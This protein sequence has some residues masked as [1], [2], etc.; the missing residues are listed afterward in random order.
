MNT[1]T[2]N[3]FSQHSDAYAQAR[4]RYPRELYDWLIAQ[5]A[6]QDAAWDCATGNG[7][8]AVDLSPYFAVV[9]ATDIS[10]EQVGEGFTQ[11]NIHYSVHPAEQTGF[12][13]NTFDL[14][15]VAQALHW[16]DFPKFW[17]E[18]RRVA[19]P[20]ALFCAWG[21]AWFDCDQELDNEFVQPFRALI[22]PYWAANNRILWDGYRNEDILFPFQRITA[23]ELAIQVQWSVP[24]LIEY[25]QTWSSYKHAQQNKDVS[26]ALEEL[27][28]I[29]QLRFSQLGTL[30]ITMPLHV[31]AGLVSKE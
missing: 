9:E 20:N 25:M 24:Q 27:I 22:A 8:A 1:K 15:T 17:S 7:Q 28:R 6:K 21:Y 10:A 5:T 4:P 19:K 16:F 2:N 14:V 23:P 18:V 30:Q 26:H 11:S 12:Q 31:V 3:T 13:D 29:A